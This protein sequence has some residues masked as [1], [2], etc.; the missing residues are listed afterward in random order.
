MPF[1]K[2]LL[3]S[4]SK[5]QAELSR[6]LLELTRVKTTHYTEEELEAQDEEYL[7]SL[8]KPKPVPHAP[9]EP[10][11]TEKKPAAPKLS[12]EEEILRDKWSRLIEMIKK[13]TSRLDVSKAFWE[14]EGGS[15]GGVNALIPEW[16]GEKVGTLLQLAASAP[17]GQPEMTD[18]LLNEL[19]ADPTIPIPSNAPH[20]DLEPEETNVESR[21]KSDTDSGRPMT[22]DQAAP[23][24]SGSRTAYDIASSRAIRDVFRSAA[25]ARPDA[26]DWLGAAHIP[27]ALYADMKAKRDTKRQERRKGLK[28]KIRE[29]EAKEKERAVSDAEV[30]PELEPEVLP[31]GRF[32][33][34]RAGS[35]KLGGGVNAA[36]S[37]AGLTPE[38]RAK[39]ERERRARAAEARMRPQ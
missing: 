16:N 9:T 2:T 26:W 11:H 14:R 7:A 10:K 19:N 5:T 20:A 25:G 36:E 30:E 6:C 8:P 15:L 33:G 4:D 38:M 28:E 13:G 37:L 12:K 1:G 22:P 31:P 24:M 34:G 18:W 17:H 23:R 3:T 29:R 39:I 32:D 35:Q 21:E 27:S